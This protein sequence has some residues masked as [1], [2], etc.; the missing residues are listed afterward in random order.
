MKLIFIDRDGVINKDPGG[1]TKHGY[2]TRLED[3][4]FL[5]GALE[6]IK[7]LTDAGYEILLISNQAG[8]NKGYYTLDSLNEITKLMLKEIEKSG[9]EIKSVYYCPHRPDENCDC[10]KPNTGLFKQATLG[11]KVNFSDTYFI[12]DGITDVKAGNDIGC[13]TVLVLSGKTDIKD[14]ESSEIK[15]NIIRKDLKEAVDYILSKEVRCQPKKS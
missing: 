9:G 2:V 8:I 10:R 7:D 13:K 5:P 14:A 3:F 12:G 6:A 11:R 15:P 4:H 1:W